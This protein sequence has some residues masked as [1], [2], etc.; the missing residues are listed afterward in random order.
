MGG[1]GVKPAGAESARRVEQPQ[2]KPQEVQ[3]KPREQQQSQSRSS[4]ADQNQSVRNARGE[5]NFES[6]RTP[7]GPELMPKQIENPTPATSTPTPSDLEPKPSRPPTPLP[8][9]TPAVP[10]SAQAQPNPDDHDPAKAENQDQAAYRIADE[11]NPRY[12]NDPNKRA[13]DLVALSQQRPDWMPRTYQELGPERSAALMGNA[14]TGI[15]A[16]NG[17]D[18]EKAAQL[19]ALGAG[20]G[21]AS[22]GQQAAIAQAAASDRTSAYGMGQVLKQQGPSDDARRAFVDAA[23]EKASAK[24][25]DFETPVYARATLDA[26]SGSQDLVNERMAKD[27]P[28]LGQAIAN[29]V[30]FQPDYAST[31]PA[32]RNDGL[33]R[34]VGMAANYQGENAATAKADVFRNAANGLDKGSDPRTQ[35]LVQEMS[36]LYLSDPQGITSA[37][38]NEQKGGP[39]WD[40]K[41]DSLPRFM[42]DALFNGQAGQD[43]AE[44]LGPH[45]EAMKTSDPRTLGIAVA[46]VQDGYYQAMKESKTNGTAVEKAV[47]TLGS[48]ATAMLPT[49]ANKVLSEAQKAIQKEFTTLASKA[50]GAATQKEREEYLQQAMDKLS[51][52]AHPPANTEAE[53]RYSNGLNVPGQYHIA[54]KNP[55]FP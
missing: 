52:Q 18:E 34:V 17:S 33:E 14:V 28:G 23:W 49:A 32:L 30:Q 25:G 3:S 50:V 27:G 42:R 44:Q 16:S 4:P 31:S 47:N 41:G 7:K 53:T 43:F 1:N 55:G 36:K 37:M 10:E 24:E 6:A 12:A 46:T 20:L 22:P 8:S 45:L 38:Y 2:S 51:Q 15:R 11:K 40:T 29:G 54:H 19:Q 9:A 39:G 13:D 35:Q 48:I 21:Q 26:L 5:S